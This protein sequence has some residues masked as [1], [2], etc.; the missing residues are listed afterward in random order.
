MKKMKI[1]DL[2]IEI[3][4]DKLQNGTRIIIDNEIFVFNKN[5]KN[6]ELSQ[7]RTKFRI[8][9]GRELND[10]IEILPTTIEVKENE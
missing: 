5:K 3:A 4:T 2:L 8:F 9:Y 10:M 7:D 6:L 1:I